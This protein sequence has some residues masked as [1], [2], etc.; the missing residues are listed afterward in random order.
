MAVTVNRETAERV[1]LKAFE[2]KVE[3]NDNISSKIRNVINGTHLTYKYILVNAL[4]AKASNADV[5]AL[6]LQA[7]APSVGAFDAR[8]LCHKV[9][10]P[11]ERK[12]LNNSLGGSNEPFLNKPAR[13]MMLGSD[14]AVRAG[15]DRNTLDS[16]IDI[17]SSINSTE[18]AYRYLC[19]AMFVLNERISYIDSLYD[20]DVNNKT[21]LS[22]IYN[23]ILR[24]SDKPCN[25]EIC[26]LIVSTLE[27]L[28]YKS[29]SKDYEII[30]HK[31][32]ESGSSSYEIGDIDIFHQN[33]LI[34][35]IEVKDKNFTDSDIEHA[36]KKA[37]EAKCEK[38][39]FIY[40]RSAQFDKEKVYSIVMQYQNK[41]LFCVLSSLLPYTRQLL[42]R[43]PSVDRHTFLT[44]LFSIEKTI[45]CK[46]DTILWVRQV[47]DE[48]EWTN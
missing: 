42:Y 38:F 39:M 8:S 23:F 19:G 45:Q 47:V 40:G 41:G 14:N 16:L 37:L 1:L 36:L 7:G 20:I 13:F 35:A 30:P 21:N 22:D 34:A 24:L 43:L 2:N 33:K 26:A 28:F 4:L 48:L 46:E 3:Q 12:Y 15:K 11:F 44:S 25:G 27:T 32:N 5:D 29:I 18:E 31:V 9:L 6:C 17:L 10:V